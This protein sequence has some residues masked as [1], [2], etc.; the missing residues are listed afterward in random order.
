[1]RAWFRKPPAPEVPPPE[2]EAVAGIRAL[3]VNLAPNDEQKIAHALYRLDAMVRHLDQ[4]PSISGQRREEF[5]REA[6]VHI[7]NLM[8]VDRM[9]QVTAEAFARRFNL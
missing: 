7:A 2:I 1:M 5:K 8:H 4:S 3:P 6:R 9:D